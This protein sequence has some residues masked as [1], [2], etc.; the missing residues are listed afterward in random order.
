VL[1]GTKFI[2]VAARYGTGDP[3]SIMEGRAPVEA[4]LPLGAIM[5]LPATG[6]EMNTFSVISRESTGESWRSP[7]R[8]FILN[9]RVWIR[10]QPFRCRNG[11]SRTVL[12]ILS[13]M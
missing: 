12:L 10:K 2:A 3:W 9:S 11:R 7:R 5:T 13:P 1:D 6:S 4:A 8:T